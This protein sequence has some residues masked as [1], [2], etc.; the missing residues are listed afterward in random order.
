MVMGGEYMT[1]VEEKVE[2]EVEATGEDQW[3]YW[4]GQRLE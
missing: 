1:G 3:Q 2:E 4:E